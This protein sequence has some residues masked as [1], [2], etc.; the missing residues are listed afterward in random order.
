M[1]ISSCP[2]RARRGQALPAATL[3]L[4]LAA[5][6]LLASCASLPPGTEARTATITRTAHGV[7]HIVAPDLETLAYATAY[8]HTED[9][10]CMTADHLLTV[11][12][13]RS[14]TFG[15]SAQGLLGLRWLPNEVIDAYV[16]T[17][18]DDAALERAWAGASAE[19]QAMARG[20][21]AG[22]NRFLADRGG[23]LP[24]P[25]AGQTWV[26]PMTLGDFRRFIEILSMQAGQAALADGVV[27][28]RPPANANPPT[29][30]SA[31]EVEL[32]QAVAAFRE[33]GLVDPPYGSNAWAFGRDT[34]ANGRGVLLGNPHF[35]WVGTNRFWQMHLTIPGRLDVM[36]ASI[37]WAPWVQ[38]GFNRDVA[39]SH[40]VSTGVRFT[41]HELQLVEGDPTAYRVDGQVVKMQRRDAAVQV[42]AADGTLATR[43]ATAWMTRFGPV[44]VVPPAG[45]NWT[46]RTA[47][48]L[49][50]VNTGNVQSGDTWLGFARARNVRDLHQS[51]RNLGIPWVNTIAADR[52]GN[53]MYA[54]V[55]RVPDMDAALLARC[56]PSRP[57]A[58]LL[59]AARIAVVDGSRSE[60][61][62]RRDGASPQPGVT[63]LERMPVAVRSD[64]VH[65]SNDSFIYTH[66]AQ[67][68]EGISPLV[69]DEV[70][71]RFRTRSGLIELPELMARSP[72]TPEAA[73]GQLFLNR[74]LAAR[75]VLPDLLAACATTP[76]DSAEARDGCTALRGWDRNNNLDS[77][78]A[79]VFREFWRTA[80]ALPNVHRV[81]FDPSQPT[82]TPLGLRLSDPAVAPKVWEALARA[83]TQVRA[84][85]FALDAPLGSVQRAIT[86]T[87]PLGL[88]G[89]DETE[90]VLNNLGDRRA[91]GITARGLQMDYGTS[92]LQAVGFDDRGPVARAV[93]AFG[94]SSD[95]ASPRATDQTRLFARKEVPVLPFHPE[96]VAAARV[97]ETLRLAR[98]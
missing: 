33:V 92:Y 38:I 81:P 53:A 3:T 56:A 31:T 83:V 17:T 1:T 66:P 79:H 70:M 85:G 41:L 63:P 62:W 37:G 19:S 34:S 50:D 40:T 94:Q 36:G 91:P 73:L 46:A 59:R 89:G 44:V 68:F 87:E 32:A 20:W 98:P 12:G 86:S 67:R 71:R 54:D 60:C 82:T 55:S 15:G 47:Y 26:Q 64:W 23:N 25:C 2:I 88:H 29:A 28:A 48:A 22:F 65:N 96:D 77:R 52:H 69:G 51:M 84:A 16:A 43:P 30:Q 18:V 58:G 72:V 74:N 78:G 45:L 24:A 8:A 27:R 61:N 90:G 97:G 13:E 9:N 95:P 14:R 42:R 4:A 75:I 10:V 39:W 80:S 93:L 35:P 5:T 49:Q 76:P 57:A 6:A 11:R 7:P 21:V